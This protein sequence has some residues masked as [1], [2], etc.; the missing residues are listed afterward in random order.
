M[1]GT[2]SDNDR[3]PRGSS[4]M[5]RFTDSGVRIYPLS[6]RAGDAACSRTRVE[7]LSAPAARRTVPIDPSP[8][9]G[10]LRRGVEEGRATATRGSRGLD[11]IVGRGEA[12][13]DDDF[14]DHVVGRV[15]GIAQ[16]SEDGHPIVTISFE[17]S[18]D[19]CDDESD[20]V[21]GWMASTGVIGRYFTFKRVY[22]TGTG[23]GDYCRYKPRVLL[24]GVRSALVDLRWRRWGSP[25]AV[26][27]GKVGFNSCV[28]NC[29]QARP[30]YHPVRAPLSETSHVRRPCAISRAP[31]PSQ[32]KR[33][34]A[35]LGEDVPRD[36]PCF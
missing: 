24:F 13:T 25:R 9:R 27:R 7:S 16:G 17:S 14:T 1:R 23:R 8:S 12:L 31:V 2:A 36:V 26:A 28:P 18:D 4:R 22:V 21:A 34:T 33:A 29:A 20:V 5:M 3:R 35:G 6:L 15:L 19:A 11:N 30:A 10:R 32:L